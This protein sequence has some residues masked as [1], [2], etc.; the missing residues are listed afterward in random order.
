MSRQ[1]KCS[2]NDSYVIKATQP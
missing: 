2:S 1:D